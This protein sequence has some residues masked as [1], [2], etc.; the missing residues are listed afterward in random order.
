M[1]AACESGERFSWSALR[2]LKILEAPTRCGVHTEDPCSEAHSGKPRAPSGLGS[3]QES[4]M[5]FGSVPANKK[6]S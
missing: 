4:G 1:I 5:S 2:G 3:Y 6:A